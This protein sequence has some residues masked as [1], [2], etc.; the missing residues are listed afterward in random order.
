MES[1][2]LPSFYTPCVLTC[3]SVIQ[4][5]SRSACRVLGLISSCL[6]TPRKLT[7]RIPC[8]I[9][10]NRQF[11]QGVLLLRS[12]LSSKFWNS[13]ILCHYC[14]EAHICLYLLPFFS[15]MPLWISISPLGCP[16]RIYGFFAQN[17][18]LATCQDS[19]N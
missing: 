17:S 15:I 18:P 7:S 9:T 2:Q 4:L 13:I 6:V 14:V 8:Q 19:R 10:T 3:T 12:M 16:L 5:A 1:G 11:I